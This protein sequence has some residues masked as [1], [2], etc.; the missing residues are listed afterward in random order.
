MTE[1]GRILLVNR[2]DMIRR[3]VVSGFN[4]LAKSS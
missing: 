3:G 2:D 1:S 4:F